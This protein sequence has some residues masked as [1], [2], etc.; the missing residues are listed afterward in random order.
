MA[1]GLWLAEEERSTF[2][3]WIAQMHAKAEFEQ[4]I[5]EAAPPMPSEGGQSGGVR[6][7]KDMAACPFRAFAVHRLRAKPLEDADL[8]LNYRDRGATVHKAL[9]YIWAELGSHAQL[10]D[11]SAADLHALVAAMRGQSRGYAGPGHRPG[12]GKA[13]TGATAG[14][15][16]GN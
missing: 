10:I 3:G 9:E 6:L 15:V 16:A 7:F 12:S 4:L 11:L 8:G 2:D 1:D 5:D 14:R 13:A